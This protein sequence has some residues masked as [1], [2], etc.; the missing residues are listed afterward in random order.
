MTIGILFVCTGNICRSPTAV[1][2]FR[3]LAERAGLADRFVVESAGVYGGHAGQPP[4]AAA[5][6]AA[7]R[8]GFDITTAH[9]QVLTPEIMARFD[10]L[11]AMDRTHLAAMRWIAPSGLIERPQL[12][13]KYAPA[14]GVTDV[15]DPFGGTADDYNR[16]VALIEAGCKGLLAHMQ[17][18]IEASADILLL[19]RGKAAAALSSC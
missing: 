7:A 10:Y 13:L 18:V 8:R 19:P 6:E 15:L 4:A 17:R 5:I 11:I 1:A 16:A 14:F 2:V 3:K 9:A 12:L